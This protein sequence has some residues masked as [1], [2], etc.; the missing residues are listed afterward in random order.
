MHQSSRASPGGGLAAPWPRSVLWLLDLGTLAAW[1]IGATF[2]MLGPPSGAFAANFLAWT[3]LTLGGSQRGWP[4]S[5]RAIML[6]LVAV[7]ALSAAAS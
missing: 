4:R 7:L 2:L 6:L 1:L 5:I 3:L